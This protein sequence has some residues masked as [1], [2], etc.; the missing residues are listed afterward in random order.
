MGA[1]QTDPRLA[2]IVNA[3]DI[4]GDN[5]MRRAS[6]VRVS[7]LR[8]VVGGAHTPVQQKRAMN[9][10][11]RPV[12]IGCGGSPCTKSASLLDS[13]LGLYLLLFLTETPNVRS[14]L[15]R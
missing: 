1:C 12:N 10:D 11:F 15:G 6:G 5:E 14:T 2:L 4:V 7:G 9:G 3:L 8:D 13:G